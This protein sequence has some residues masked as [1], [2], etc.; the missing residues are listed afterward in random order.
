MFFGALNFEFMFKV[1]K[2]NPGKFQNPQ[3]IFKKKKAAA[4]ERENF[5]PNYA[6]DA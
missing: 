2:K 4:K 3:K 6:T 5:I 1:E